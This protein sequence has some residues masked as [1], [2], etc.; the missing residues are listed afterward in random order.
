MKTIWIVIGFLSLGLAA[1]GMIL[2]QRIGEERE[3]P[4]QRIFGA[5]GY[6]PT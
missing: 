4:N 1:F 5:L 3:T 6:L 2:S